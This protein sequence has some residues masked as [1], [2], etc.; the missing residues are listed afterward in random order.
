MTF[1]EPLTSASDVDTRAGTD[2]GGVVIYELPPDDWGRTFGAI[3]FRDGIPGDTPGQLTQQATPQPRSATDTYGRMTLDGGTYGIP[4]G[5][6]MTAP[7]LRLGIEQRSPDDGTPVVRARI[8]SPLLLDSAWSDVTVPAGALTPWPG[9]GPQARRDGAGNAHWRGMVKLTGSLGTNLSVTLPMPAGFAPTADQWRLT[10]MIDT[11][12][13]Y[14][15]PVWASAGSNGL[16]SLQNNT[17]ATRTAG[18]AFAVYLSY[19]IT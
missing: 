13:S 17:G 10:F 5:G 1:R 3:E 14:L 11:N 12:G 4:G 16:L 19:P 6:T 18:Q 8:T 7:S 9:Q 2:A 15:G